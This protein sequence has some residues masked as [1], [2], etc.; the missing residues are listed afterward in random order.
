[1][2]QDRFLIFIITGISLIAL[3]SF[4]MSPFFHISSIEFDGLEIVRENEVNS[5]IDNYYGE[6]IWLLDKT[7]LKN[8]LEQTSMIKRVQVEK[9]FPDKI[10]IIV[11]ERVPLAKINNNGKYLLFSSSG[12]IIEEG[13]VN[14][15]VKV[16][17]IIGLGYS[18][19]QNNISFTP[20]L[21]KIVQ[22]LAQVDKETRELINK[23]VCQDK[24]IT[25]YH[26]N[27]PV[28]LNNYQELNKK[29]RILESIF[30][31]IL[32]EDIVVDYIDLSLLEKPVIKLNNQ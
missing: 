14:M 23:I 10:H 30:D 32:Q 6:N 18:L 20:E 8:R 3:F 31:K 12:F 29:F 19:N 4:S 21:E 5:L 13:A 9:V 22:A 16:P 15:R 17:E 11:E 24:E 28:Y 25:A 26:N 27:I 2:E 7:V 1:M